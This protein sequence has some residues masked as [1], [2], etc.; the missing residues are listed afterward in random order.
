MSTTPPPT[1]AE[2]PRKP[3]PEPGPRTP[4]I[5][6]LAGLNLFVGLAGLIALLALACRWYAIGSDA[7]PISDL[8]LHNAV[9]RHWLNGALALGLAA[10]ATLTFAGFGLLRMKRWGLKATFFY[11][12]AALGLVLLG[13]IVVFS[14]FGK[15]LEG[16]QGL[17]KTTF[18][19]QLSHATDEDVVVRFTTAD[20][21]ATA[22]EDYVAT[23]GL[24]TIPAGRTSRT[25]TTWT[26]GD[27]RP[28]PTNEHFFFTLESPQGA[29]LG[30]QASATATIRED[31]EP[32]TLWVNDM[33]LRERDHGRARAIFRL[34][35]SRPCASNVT[36]DVSTRDGTATAPAD[37][38]PQSARLTIPAWSTNTQF[39]VDVLGDTLDERGNENLHLALSNIT[40]AALLTPMATATIL[41]D[42]G[43]A[44]LSVHDVRFAELDRGLGKAKFHL[45]LTHP[46]ASNVTVR[47]TTRNLEAVAGQDY[48]AAEGLA[49]IAAWRTNATITVR[50]PGDETV[51]GAEARF[52]LD[53]RD[54]VNATLV[55]NVAFAT[56]VDNDAMPTMAIDSQKVPELNRGTSKAFLN[57]AL[58]RPYREPITVQYRTVAGT[59]Q[60][61]QDYRPIDGILTIPSGETNGVIPVVVLG[62][63][64]REENEDLAV[65]LANPVNAILIETNGVITIRDDDGVPILSVSDVIV[66][67]GGS[68]EAP[69]AVA[70][71][72]MSQTGLRAGGLLLLVYPIV[73][74]VLLSRPQ[75]LG[76]FGISLTD[77]TFTVGTLSYTKAGLTALFAWLLW[78]DFVFTIMEAVVP[79]VLPLK[80]ESLGASSTLMSVI[81]TTLPAILN[82][83]VCPW[84]SFKSDRHRGRWGRRIPFIVW[85]M[86]FLTLTLMMLGWSE[87]IAVWLRHSIPAV[88]AMAPN[89]LIILMIAIF[90]VLFQFF[91]L[92]VN[93]VFWYLFNDVV[94]AQFLGRFMG[95]FRIVGVFAG[96]L[97]HGFIFKFAETHMREILTGG[98]LVYLVGFGLMC[99]FVR[100]G[101][102]PPITGE[103]GRPKGLLS[104]IKTY[105]KESFSVRFYWYFFLTGAVGRIAYSLGMFNVF[106]SKQMGLTLDQMGKLSM[107]GAIAGMVATYFTATLVDR[108]HPLRIVTY[109]KVFTAVTGF[110]AWIWLCVTLPGDLYFW[111]ALLGTMVTTFNY[112]LQ[113][114]AGYPLLMRLLPKSR[115]GQFSSAAALIRS[116]ATIGA[117]LIAGLYM[118]MLKWLCGG[119]DYAYRLIF[120]WVWPFNILA[121]ALMIM[122]YR[123]WKRMGGDTHYRPPAPWSPDGYE[124]SVDKVKSAPAKPHA[125][126]FALNLGVIGSVLNILFILVFMYY[127]YLHGMI[128]AVRWHAMWFIPAK[129]ILT[130]I[131]IW[132]I[133]SVKRDIA[134]I[135]RGETPRYGIPHHGVFLV[136]NIT[137][138][139]Y[140]PVYWVQT[141]WMIHIDLQ[142]ELIIFGINAL[143]STMAGIVA[144]HIIRW[145]E[146][147]QSAP[148]PAA[149]AMAASPRPALP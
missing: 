79:T 141:M 63:R 87:P 59:A 16:H 66:R 69:E 93:S 134:A 98:A 17:A 131:M 47:Y 111:T 124:D 41:D 149:T 42:D 68:A 130:A 96:A 6:A 51:D 23:N 104:D 106:F 36:V 31:D 120:L 114:T 92:F 13:G 48:Q 137:N 82:M 91:N 64:T 74:L 81:M 27:N 20:G 110:G 18:R 21:D 105:S 121:T 132:Q 113:D 109:E 94:P 107:Y 33:T 126:I 44:L 14:H 77:T 54:A 115:Y 10:C 86:P 145:T 133:N 35:L 75:V 78:G 97:Y 73:L 45:Q 67:E 139:L 123:D 146:R 122:A 127:M 38:T 49:T 40:F 1:G 60:E 100:E 95:L 29:E 112:V 129:V 80:L 84:V 43:P 135:D 88:Q 62:D 58:S 53:L 26:L 11:A 72:A 83:T 85:T 140:F 9:A 136:L 76:P 22:G 52:A 70:L 56:I 147:V 39:I 119:S 34:Q 101:Q 50:V 28:E 128:W 24:L 7:G 148:E 19:V 99:I 71:A 25:I 108:W 30:E 55:T 8:V 143:L 46:I 15:A 118:D 61:G 57:V 90:L 89:T 144:V 37:Y 32:I 12:V 3:A 116:A 125:A 65:L 4:R 102:Y 117:G 5:L 103:A 142:Y 138:L 2:S